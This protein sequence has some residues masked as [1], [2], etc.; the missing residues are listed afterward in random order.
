MSDNLPMP[1]AGP[2]TNAQQTMVINLVRRAARAEIMPRFRKLDSGEVSKKSSVS[3]LVTKADT[4]AEAMITRGLQIAFPSALIVG[5][6]AV[7]TDPKLLDKIGDADLCFLIDPVDGTWNFANGM[8]VFGTMIAVCRFGVP[9]FG[10][11]YDPVGDD[12]ILTDDKGRAQHRAASGRNRTLA[13]A[14]EKPLAEL[15][16][17][18][19]TW[20]MPEDVRTVAANRFSEFQSVTS[21]GCSAYHYRLLAQ[22]AVD[23]VLASKLSPWDHAA[24]VLLC[25][26]SGGH[27]AMLDGKDYN[28]TRR[29]GYLLCASSRAVWETVGTQLSDLHATG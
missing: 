20:L 2:L 26:Q 18:G 14:G 16:G 29:E 9:A 12:L 10:L 4:A 7:E 22:G 3:D 23:F 28:A 5:E 6:E 17:Y 13:T 27:A 1:I 24:G 19:E 25:K 11:I 8:P 21:L 15:S